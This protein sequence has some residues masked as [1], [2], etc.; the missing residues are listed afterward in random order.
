MLYLFS[1]S[2]PPI[3]ISL[4]PLSA[5]LCI[6]LP[7]YA[8]PVTPFLPFLECDFLSVDTMTTSSSS[9]S[10]CL[11]LIVLPSYSN[12]ALYKGRGNRRGNTGGNRRVEGT[13]EGTVETEGMEG[14]EGTGAGAIW[15]ML[16]GAADGRM[17]G[18]GH[19]GLGKVS[20]L[21]Y[22][23]AGSKTKTKNKEC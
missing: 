17:G 6:S 2:P 9:A 12:D 11:F 16:Q 13:V 23:L 20:Y 5:S 19:G 22:S 3:S 10:A 4:L 18:Q 15:S 21:A 1:H 14:K 8:T 7:P